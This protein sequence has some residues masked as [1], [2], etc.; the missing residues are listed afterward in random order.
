MIKS[1]L[2]F[3]LCIPVLASAQ[4][5]A[6]P[7]GT[8]GPI[9]FYQFLPPSYNGSG[10]YKYP[11]IINMAGTLE[12]GNGTTDLPLVLKWGLGQL[13][14]SSPTPTLTFNING[15]QHAFVV[16]IPQLAAGFQTWQNSYVDAMI[17]YA[18]ANLNIDENKIFLTGYSLG[19]GG[20]WKYP[21]ESLANANRIAGII[22]VAP[23]PNYS[24]LCNL[25]QGKVAVWAHQSQD[26]DAIPVRFTDSAIEV[27]KG[28]SPI[29]PPLYSRYN[30]GKHDKS[31]VWAY[32]TTNNIQYPNIWQWMIGT[33]RANSRENNQ[34]PVVSAGND[35]ILA[36]PA[37]SAVLDGSGSYD[38][39]DVIVKYSWAKLSG[40]NSYSIERPSY[41][42]TNIT[43]L[44]TGV[45]NFQLTV[46]DQFGVMRADDMKIF[47]NTVLP[48]S[49]NFFKAKN[50]SNANVLNWQTSLE[51]NASSFIV[52]RSADGS[53]FSPVGT[54]QAGGTEYTFTDTNAP[55]GVSYYRLQQVDKDG[56]FTMSKIISVKNLNQLLSIEKYPNPVM[57]KLNLVLE[58]SVNGVFD[59]IIYDINGKL[60]NRQNISKQAKLWKGSINT[61][62]FK[63]GVYSLHVNGPGGFVQ[64]ST[65]M[66]Q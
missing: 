58:G 56:K 57:D 21:T 39:N 27:I 66:K 24:E 19:G 16:L 53:N 50:V 47:V 25:A 62:L 48:V 22:P 7:A 30:D 23:A 34:D 2:L 18:R 41:P 55:S 51:V 54:L 10:A 45:Y 32:D 5:T 40:P 43:G 60:V 11:L 6:K 46:T 61:G 42:V 13:L 65:F 31:W 14:N 20:A 15:K 52:L 8:A 28:C 3:L 33:S 12:S 37:T 63:S 64:S 44:Q 38:P 1:L 35:I 17:D 29:I 9:G 4:L 49:M 36:T 59:I 26:D